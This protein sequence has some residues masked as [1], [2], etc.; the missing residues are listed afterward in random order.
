MFIYKARFLTRGEVWYDEKPNG[1]RV[2]WVYY[3]QRSSPLANCR[4]NPFYTWLIDLRKTPAEMFA[5]MADR[6]ARRI[7]E[8]AAEDGL[9]C[10]RC[11]AKDNKLINEVEAMWNRFAAAHN[12]PPLERHW[13]DPIKEAGGLDL[14]AAKD[15]AGN[16]LAYHLV[17]LTPKR[18]RQIIAISSYRAVPTVAW[19]TA[20]SRANC[21]IHWHNF[22]T[23]S[24]RGI[25]D[26][27]FGGWYP[28][29][30]DI[31]LLG[32]N[33]FKKSFGGRVV[34]EYDCDQ[35][36]TVKGWLLLTVAQI[37]ARYR[38]GA[39]PA[40]TAS[41]DK[42]DAAQPAEHQVSPAL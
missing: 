8:A 29:T 11:D 14:V 19:R 4:S 40:R 6:T 36:V 33:R 26:F 15:R 7:T 21:L 37:L 39:P 2:D 3:R 22:L 38:N 5:A 10:E 28:G 12:T 30:I 41:E 23:F 35:P 32:I 16:I 17:F 27:D 1:A 42:N 25:H 18:A 34:R 9:R 20:V 13:L 31:R 24:E